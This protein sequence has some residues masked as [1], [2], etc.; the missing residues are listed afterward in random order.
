MLY[1]LNIENIKECNFVH[2]ISFL[3][4]CNQLFLDLNQKVK[5]NEAL[6]IGLLVLLF[7]SI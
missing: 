7:S 1:M 2:L 6:R 5:N 4:N 3:L